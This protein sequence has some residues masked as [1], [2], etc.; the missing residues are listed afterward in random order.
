MER[1]LSLK[2]EASLTGLKITVVWA[3]ARYHDVSLLITSHLQ[4]FSIVAAREK[5]LV[6]EV[7]CAIFIAIRTETAAAL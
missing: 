2:N 4:K 7:S 6:V 1:I 5:I 3:V